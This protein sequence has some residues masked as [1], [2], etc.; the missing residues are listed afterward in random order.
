[1]D[2]NK[3]S[4]QELV[5]VF[6]RN[7]FKMFYINS[8]DGEN[9]SNPSGIFISLGITTSPT[10]LE[11]IK[12][13]LISNGYNAVISEIVSKKVA[14]QFMNILTENE[15]NQYEL[16]EFEDNILDRDKA[17]Q[18][19]EELKNKVNPEQDLE[20]LKVLVPKLSRLEELINKLDHNNG[21]SIHLIQET[22]KTF[23]LFHRFVNYKKENELEYRIGIYVSECNK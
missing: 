1:M 2:I 21:W 23:N 11:D 17:L 20:E 15:P 3:G 22:D 12:S 9:F 8:T 16:T 10:V 14:G 5:S 6:Y 7:T 13:I 19:L 18:V 4:I